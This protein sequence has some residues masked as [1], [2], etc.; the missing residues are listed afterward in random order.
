M[1]MLNA[2]HCYENDKMSIDRWHRIRMDVLLLHNM[3]TIFVCSVRLQMLLLL[4]YNMEEWKKFVFCCC[5][6]SVFLFCILWLDITAECWLCISKPYHFSKSTILFSLWNFYDDES[7]IFF[8]IPMDS[9]SLSLSERT[10][11]IYMRFVFIKIIFH[12]MFI[13]ILL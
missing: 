8:F 5:L 10:F 2:A 13:C 4:L 6:S 11:N 9:L 1:N 7:A 3:K 12:G